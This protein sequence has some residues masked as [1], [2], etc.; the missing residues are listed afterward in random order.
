MLPNL[1]RALFPYLMAAPML[2]VAGEPVYSMSA[3]TWSRPRDAGSLVSE[4]AL[5]S[6]LSR[7][8]SSGG[9]HIVLRHPSGERGHL[10]V[11][12]LQDWLVALGVPSGHIQ[13]APTDDLETH[14]ELTINP[15]P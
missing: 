2:A 9:G 3:D 8:E 4:P 10:W 1:R 5:R 7:Y 14:I 11:A 6:T 13:Q 12:E 15:S